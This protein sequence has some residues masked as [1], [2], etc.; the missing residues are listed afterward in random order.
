MQ[1]RRNTSGTVPEKSAAAL[2]A[3]GADRFRGR[4]ATVMGLGLFG[5][6]AG[7]ARYLV[8][9]GARVTVTDLKDAAALAPSIR[10]LEGLPI[11]YHLGGHVPA[12][13]TAADILVVNPGVDKRKSGFVRLAEAAG[14]EITSEMNLFIEARPAPVLGVTGSSGKSTTTALAGAMLR[15]R[16]PSRVGGNIGISLLDEIGEIRPDE[17]VVLELS[18]FQLQDLAALEW[19]PRLA[20][21]TCISEN[22][23]DRHESM[24]NYVE[25]KKN[26]VR[27][28]SPGDI[29]VL[30]ADDEALRL[31]EPEARRR[32]SR[33]VWYSTRRPLDEGVFIDG[34]ALVFR[35][36]A[37]E[38]RVDLAGRVRLLGRHNRS[39]IAAA[40][41]AARLLDVPA[42]AIA[43]AV[44]A[45]RPL[46]HRLEPVGRLGDV[47]FV[48]DSKAT[49][50]AAAAV[51]MEAFEQRPIVLIAGGRDKD[52]KM[53]PMI[54]ALR[55]RA[56]AAVLIGE[57]AGPIQEALGPGG[58]P[59]HRAG[60]MA[61]AVA[62]AVRIARPGD[63][64]LLAP[65]YTSL[66]MFDNYERRGDAFRQ[67]ARGLGME[68]L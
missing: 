43:A 68:P 55:R 8:N 21:T 2:C 27:F 16:R 57:M 67:A 17:W 23:L 9:R 42:E 25:A 32:G 26:I 48:D 28:Q 30:N 36:G 47:L 58:P 29:V 49:T 18:S 52:M 63:V 50:P 34:P 7:A 10:A 62:R 53:A 59:V 38:E 31:W 65:G 11:T 41:A 44:G 1:A 39:N 61:E 66:D 5:G 64:V 54:E 22:H 13:F 56:R 14:A 20:V 6:G 24:E 51:S 19:S 37:A 4:A 12:D 15:G 40:A 35:L 33:T 3:R 60:G 45:F 46:P